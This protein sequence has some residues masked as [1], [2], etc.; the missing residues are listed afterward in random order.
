MKLLKVLPLFLILISPLAQ[1]GS[2]GFHSVD[3]AASAFLRPLMRGVSGVSS[4]VQVLPGSSEKESNNPLIAQAKASMPEN[5]LQGTLVDT[6]R[7]NGKLMSYSK[8]NQSVLLGGKLVKQFYTLQFLNGP[9]KELMLRIMQLTMSG[10]YQI[11]EAQI[12]NPVN[13]DSA[14]SNSR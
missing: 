9:K 13:M 14:S 1:A 5:P 7:M 2:D 3:E 11:V 10:G 6:M 12:S 8:T 4:S